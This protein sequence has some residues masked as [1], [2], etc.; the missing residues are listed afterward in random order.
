MK[1]IN[2]NR[3]GLFAEHNGIAPVVYEVRLTIPALELLQS[4]GSTVEPL[5]S[6]LGYRVT[7][8]A[9]MPSGLI[10]V[11]VHG[12]PHVAVRLS[13][14]PEYPQEHPDYWATV[15]FTPCPVCGA[16]V[17]WYEAGYV[18]GYRVCTGLKHHHSVA[19]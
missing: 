13:S 19:E 16:P 3:R 2:Q 15:D 1:L 6:R 12:S 7:L 17:V 4:A 8:G 18:P 11:H 14:E 9:K 10:A 5:P